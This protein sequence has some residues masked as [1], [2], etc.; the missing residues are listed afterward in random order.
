MTRAH[1]PLCRWA[2]AFLDNHLAT[3][4]TRAC[5]FLFFLFRLVGAHKNDKFIVTVFLICWIASLWPEE[6]CAFLFSSHWQRVIVPNCFSNYRTEVRKKKKTKKL[7]NSLTVIMDPFCSTFFDKM[8]IT[9]F[10]SSLFQN[11]RVCRGDSWKVNKKAFFSRTVRNWTGKQRKLKR[12]KRWFLKLREPNLTFHFGS[13]F[14]R[15]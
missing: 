2:V 1:I 9:F 15:L 3:I 8:L 10:S 14:S 11:S 12:E 7:K 5:F 13:T 4:R 6:R